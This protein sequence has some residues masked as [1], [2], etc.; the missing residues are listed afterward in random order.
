MDVVDSGQQN[1]GCLYANSKLRLTTESNRLN[2]LNSDFSEHSGSNVR[3][4]YIFVAD[5]SFSLNPYV[6]MPHPA[7]NLNDPM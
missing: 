3:Y 5:D 4:P 2:I 6:I 1:D 7:A